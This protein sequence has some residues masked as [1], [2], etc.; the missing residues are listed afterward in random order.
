[1][2]ST[3]L[4]RAGSLYVPILL[5]QCCYRCNLLYSKERISLGCLYFRKMRYA[6]GSGYCDWSSR[7]R[8]RFGLIHTTISDNQQSPAR[9]KKDDR[10]AI[11]LHDRMYVGITAPQFIFVKANIDSA[12]VGSAAQLVYKVKVFRGNDPIWDGI[13]VAITT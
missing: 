5:V 2:A 7:C 3:C 4:V 6:C 10:P 8:N 1:M 9:A 13:K 11:C 12:V